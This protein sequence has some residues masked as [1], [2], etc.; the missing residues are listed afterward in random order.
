MF[1]MC[2]RLGIS[3]A[4]ETLTACSALGEVFAQG[5]LNGRAKKDGLGGACW[6]FIQITTLKRPQ[7]R[8]GGDLRPAGT[9]VSTQNHD[10]VSAADRFVVKLYQGEE[11]GFSGSRC[12]L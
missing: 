10:D 3:G 7:A 1:H 8:A 12:R 9:A 6:A 4:G 2:Y 11:L 5:A